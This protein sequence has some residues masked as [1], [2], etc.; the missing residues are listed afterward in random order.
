MN[1][2]ELYKLLVTVQKNVRCP[3]CG[4]QYNFASIQIR[5]VVDS[6]VFLELNCVNHMPL[7][8]TVTLS[9]QSKQK[10]I[11]KDNVKPDDVIETYRLLKD[12]Q[13]PLSELFKDNK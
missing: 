2:Q 8:A 6:I 11:H 10:Q 12:W 1:H 5:G 13:Q 4:K 7:L 9:K 3:Q